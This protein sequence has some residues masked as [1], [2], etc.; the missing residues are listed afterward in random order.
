MAIGFVEA[1]GDT[2][3]ARYLRLTDK[4][5]RAVELGRYQ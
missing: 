4:G 5:L 2:D 1:R 3:G